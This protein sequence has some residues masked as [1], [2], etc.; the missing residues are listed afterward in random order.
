MNHKTIFGIEF[1]AVRGAGHYWLAK[2]V[3]TQKILSTPAKATRPK[4]W[5]ELEHIARLRGEPRFVS[6]T[7]TF[8]L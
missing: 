2:I 3:A 6:E 7:L 1:E 5:A 8:T 4:L